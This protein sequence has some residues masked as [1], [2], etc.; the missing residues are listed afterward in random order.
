MANIDK[1]VKVSLVRCD[2]YGS[3]EVYKKVG[4]A[5]DLLGG[6]GR[7]V[8]KGERVIVK[9]N[10]LSA[11]PPKK[12]V[13]THP[14]V[15]EA[16]VKLVMDAGGVPMIGDSPAIGSLASCLSKGEFIPVI[17]KYNVT[18]L[19]FDEPVTLSNPSGMFKSFQVAREITEADKIIN[20]PKL[21]THGQM[22]MTMAVK[23]LFGAVVGA[24]KTQWHLKVGNHPE[25]F[26]RM[27]L[28]L[29]YLINPTLSIMDAITA[30]EGNGP[31]SGDPVDLGLIFAGVDASAVDAVAAK[32]VGLDPSL[33]YTLAVAKREGMG[34]AELSDVEVVGER[35]EDV[36]VD[37]FRFP[38]TGPI[39]GGVPSV[40]TR[41]A[42][43]TLTPR[44]V[45]DHEACIVCGQCANICSAKAI[46][47]SETKIN[48]DYNKCIRCFCCQEICPEG[49]IQ[50]RTGFFPS[51]R[52][53]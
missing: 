50:I 28:D 41:I 7:F 46:T 15:V 2:D 31:G 13:Q 32:V 18:V 11:R 42:R 39:L 4:Q 33:L 47:E 23:N 36:S 9:P 19:K 5:V 43:R 3:G 20:V 38:P 44:P 35:V 25:K 12:A 51:L 27:L 26:A 14:A 17:K 21:K 45:V 24:R 34:V 52:K 1:R 8:S 49:A 22:V 37:G 40:I 53:S 30:M 16:V 10:M 29:H 48:I 6:I